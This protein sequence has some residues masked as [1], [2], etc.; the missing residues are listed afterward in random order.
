MAAAR[1]AEE[2]IT[3][4]RPLLK[5]VVVKQKGEIAVRADIP[6]AQEIFDLMELGKK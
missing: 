4:L 3:R 2:L 5:K 1:E 6:A